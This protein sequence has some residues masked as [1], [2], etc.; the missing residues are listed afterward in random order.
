[1]DPSYSD[2]MME[3]F[4]LSVTAYLQEHIEQRR[5]QASYNV[6]R[7]NRQDWADEIWN[8]PLDPFYMDEALPA[9]REW[10]KGKFDTEYVTT[11]QP[12]APQ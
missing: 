2:T 11:G 7:T 6:L 1:M 12:E 4:E 9:F 5:G 8:T 10:L 3:V